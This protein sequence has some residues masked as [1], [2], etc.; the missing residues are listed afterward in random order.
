MKK[1]KAAATITS[2]Q[3]FSKLKWLDGRNLLDTIEPYRRQLFAAAL[4]TFRPDGTPVYNMVLAGRGKKNWKTGDLVSAALYCVVARRRSIQSNAALIL[5]NDEGQ[6]ADDLSL[7]RRLVEANPEL[8][9][10]FEPLQKELRLRDGSGSIKILPSRDIGLH[11][12]TFCFAGFDEIH[13]YRDWNIFEA[14]AIDP[15]RPDALTWITSYDTIFNSPG[16]PLYDLK[17]IGKAGSDK[18]MLFSWYSGDLCTDVAFAALPPEQR[19]NPSMSSWPE[20]AKY[21]EQQRHRLPV[22]KYRRLHLNLP[23]APEGA[24]FDQGKLLAAIVVGRYRLPY[25]PGVAYIAFVDMSGGSSDDAVLCIGHVEGRRVIIDLL[26][27]QTGSPPFSSRDAAY[28]F[29]GLLKEYHC[30][31]VWGDTYAGQTFVQDFQLYGVSYKHPVPTASEQY[32]MF[33]PILNA[34]EV[35]LLDHGK[36]QEQFLTLVMRGAKITHVPGEH[37]D[38]SNAVAGLVWLAR[39]V[40]ASLRIPPELLA[41][42]QAMPRYRRPIGSDQR[43]A[44]AERIFGER[45]AAQ[46]AAMANRRR[47]GW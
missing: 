13:G 7:A 30:H 36:M 25:V 43:A 40:S 32:E 18:R 21:L 1:L 8:R 26:E 37:D 14:L 2:L 47:Y 6:A 29:A 33:E 3:F 45:K 20:G 12:K 9:A 11:G 23:G 35:E 34:G 27:K 5:A 4:D 42:I 31:T 44:F 38:F 17:Q 24:V 16:V 46:M 22:Y 15:T 19:A 28:K 41:Q 39:G 10:E